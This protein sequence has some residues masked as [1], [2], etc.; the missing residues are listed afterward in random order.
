MRSNSVAVNVD[1]DPDSDPNRIIRNVT[2]DKPVF[3][4]KNL[5]PGT[6]FEARVYTSN[7]KGRSSEVFVL[8]AS[9]LK[10][11][12]DKRPV[13]SLASGSATDDNTLVGSGG[14]LITSSVSHRDSSVVLKNG[15][16][17]GAS[18]SSSDGPTS[19]ISLSGLIGNFPLRT[20]LMI[21]GSF[22]VVLTVVAISI[23]VICR[24]Q[25]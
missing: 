18:L 25:F 21:A 17:E 7:Q 19:S 5:K 16:S 23:G 14:E 4:I 24:I 2:S 9:T 12:S 6:R 15:K 10:R 8:R 3:Y 22:T 13:T 11:A 20:I 1:V